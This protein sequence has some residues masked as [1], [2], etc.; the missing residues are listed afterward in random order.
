VKPAIAI[1]GA[2]LRPMRRNDADAF[3]ALLW[4]E[5]MREFLCD[6]EVT[7]RTKI[8]ETL[9]QSESLDQDGLGLWAIETERGFAGVPV[10]EIY[11][12]VGMAGEIEPLIA[13]DPADW[14]QGLATK[15]VNALARHAHDN[16]GLKRLVAA[17]DEAN[18]RS[19]RTMER[20]GFA[21]VARGAAP[22][23]VAVFYEL[24]LR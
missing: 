2:T 24:R 7:P 15:S 3:C 14:G 6:G 10:S 21:E 18:L 9:V 11:T 23:G 1:S 19:R 4:D 8:E 5:R 20:C 22:L 13:L 16:C 17:V 12:Q